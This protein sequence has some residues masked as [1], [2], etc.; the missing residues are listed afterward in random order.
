M[1]IEIERKFLVEGIAWRGLG[2]GQ[3]YVQGYLATNAQGT[4]RIRTVGNRAYLT[5]KGK[6]KNLT[7]PEFEYPIPLAEAQEMLQT[8][9]Q[10]YVVAKTRYQIHR[11]NL[12]W[13]VDEFA[14]R[15]QGLVLAEVELSI[16]D[17][18][19]ALPDWI[20]AEVSADP[21]YYNSYLAQHP[22]ATWRDKTSLLRER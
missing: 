1:A 4:V 20:G 9:C 3:A 16:P 13:E 8:L 18:A 11:D 22:Y 2:T 5:I 15:N 14:G 21:R 12:V 10:P 7:R 17:Q 6:V 19:I